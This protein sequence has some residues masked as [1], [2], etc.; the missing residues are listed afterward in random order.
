M[1]SQIRMPGF[2]ICDP[3]VTNQFISA[4]C[5]QMA[6]RTIMLQ[7]NFSIFCSINFYEYKNIS[8][9][10]KK[11]RNQSIAIPVNSYQAYSSF[12]ACTPVYKTVML[13]ATAISFIISEATETR[14]TH[15]H[16]CTQLWAEINKKVYK[17]RLTDYTVSQKNRTPVTFSNNSNILVQYRQILV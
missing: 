4:I 17:L 8:S 3:A 9:A 5:N 13:Q 16:N 7:T 6:E 14:N 1:I 12:T 11:T 10:A 2:T 15:T